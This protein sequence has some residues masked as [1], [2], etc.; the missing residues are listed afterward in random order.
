MAEL[1]RTDTEHVQTQ[2]SVAGAGIEL[3]SRSIGVT[4]RQH[5]GDT[6]RTV[7]ALLA[8]DAVI[9]QAVPDAPEI[10]AFAQLEGEGVTAGGLALLKLNCEQSRFGSQERAPAVMLDQGEAVHLRKI[11]DGLFQIRRRERGVRETAN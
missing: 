1:Q 6:G 2:A 5:R 9:R 7:V 11:V 4:Q 10:G 3:D 8:G